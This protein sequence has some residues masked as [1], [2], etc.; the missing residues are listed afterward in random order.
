MRIPSIRELFAAGF[1][2]AARALSSVP[3]RAEPRWHEVRSGPLQGVELYLDPRDGSS[4]EMLAGIYDDFLFEAL[5]EHG[6]FNEGAVVWDVGAH[7]GYDSMVF[8]SLVGSEGHVYAFE[9]NP[10]NGERL[11][12]HLA[13]NLH[14]S[15][16]V[17]LHQCAVSS[18]D[19]ELPF[20]LSSD[21]FLGSIGYLDMGD[22][23][24]SDRISHEMYERL[25]S[26]VVPVRTL[27]SLFNDGLLPP[28][29]VKIDVEG[30]EAQ[31]LEGGSDL[32]ALVKPQL[33]IE[34]HS[35]KSMFAVQRMLLSHGYVPTFFDDLRH[36]SSSRG[37]VVAE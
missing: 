24:P 26:V 4:G 32:L 28:S 1:W 36:P 5:E 3:V 15:D 14:L 2:K 6:A 30:A 20:R 29:L 11:R 12:R 7:M 19:G 27:D 9:P 10:Y 18:L 17:E 16:R 37:F 23:L 22:Q 34:V 35:I 21:Y 31:V 13:R 33:L 25:Q 8:A